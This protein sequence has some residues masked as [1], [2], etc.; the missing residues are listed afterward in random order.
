MT[1]SSLQ[2]ADG[3][4]DGSRRVL[5]VLDI[6]DDRSYDPAYA[7]VRNELTRRIVART[8]ESGWDAHIVYAENATLAEIEAQVAGADALLVAGGEDVHPQFYGESTGYVREGMHFAKADANQIE[9]VRNAVASGVPVLGI[10]RGLQIINVALGG[11]LT[12]DLGDDS[13]HRDY[14]SIR[15]AFVEHEVDIDAG[16]GLGR[17]LGEHIT[18]VSAHH[19]AIK[20]L[21]AGLVA[22]ATAPDGIIEAVTHETA[23]VLAVQWHPETEEAEHSQFPAMLAAVTSVVAR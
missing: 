10:C 7:T 1:T 9:V 8:I 3:A 13:I 23:P 6:T 14:D 20:T 5:A 21:G 22:V 11:S 4:E 12:T 18:C 15:D 17:E 16:S 2:P 19:Q